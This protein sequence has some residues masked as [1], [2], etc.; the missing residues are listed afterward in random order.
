MAQY[1]SWS[2][3]CTLRGAGN[4][5]GMDKCASCFT[6]RPSQTTNTPM[7]ANAP[8]AGSTTPL[9]PTPAWGAFQQQAQQQSLLEERQW[10]CL[11]CSS[12]NVGEIFNCASCFAARPLP[13]TNT[14]AGIN[15]PGASSIAPVGA[16]PA[17]GTRQANSAWGEIRQQHYQH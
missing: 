13:A 2:C 6:P 4:L 5:A 12:H 9:G 15:V 1:D 14:S 16:P 11:H 7:R 3:V 10:R 8:V 17:W